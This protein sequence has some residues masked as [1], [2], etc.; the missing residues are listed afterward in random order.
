MEFSREML[1]S[2]EICG[3]L[4]WG[5]AREVNSL[6]RKAASRQGARHSAKLKL[7]PTPIKATGMNVQHYIENK[8]FS[9]HSA[10]DNDITYYTI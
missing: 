4:I 7:R 2:V 3:S 6:K 10:L 9:S 8:S 5:P 1:G